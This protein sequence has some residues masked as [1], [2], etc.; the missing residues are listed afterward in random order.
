MKYD[1]ASWHYG[2]DFPAELPRSAG[3][4]HIGVFVAWALLHGLAGDI[5]LREFSEPLAQLR[6]RKITPGQFLIDACDE[7]LQTKIYPM[8]ATALQSIT[9][10]AKAALVVISLITQR[11]LAQKRR[12]SITSRTR[13]RRLITSHRLFSSA[14]RSGSGP[15]Q[16][17]KPT[18]PPR[19]K[20]SVFATT[21]CRGL[22]LCR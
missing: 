11:R 8:S 5:H 6:E 9:T 2:G 4:T 19:N 20:F 1:D 14:L 18:A 7:N 16:S 10:S 21:P 13:G 3:A 17:M 22:S 12:R 15:N